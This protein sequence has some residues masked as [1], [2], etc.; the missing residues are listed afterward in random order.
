MKV[1]RLLAKLE[2]QAEDEWHLQFKKRNEEALT[3]KDTK[4]EDR[5]RSIRRLCQL[6]QK[7]AAIKD[8]LELKEEIEAESKLFLE[9]SAKLREANLTGTDRRERDAE[10]FRVQTVLGRTVCPELS[11]TWR[12]EATLAFRN[13]KV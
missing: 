7:T 6:R 11:P 2:L 5:D 8:E 9:A 4:Q 12:D 10:S 3:P 13:K 1:E